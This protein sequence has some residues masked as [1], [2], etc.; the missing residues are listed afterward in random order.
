MLTRLID[1]HAV[2]IDNYD[3]LKDKI[4]FVLLQGYYVTDGDTIAV[5][6][7]VGDGRFS[8]ASLRVQGVDTPEVHTTNALEK[9][10]GK[11]VQNVV[12][13]W[14]AATPGE[15]LQIAEYPGGKYRG[16]FMGDV[17]LGEGQFLSERLLQH[18]LAL[19][20][21]GGTKTTWSTPALQGVIDECQKIMS[22]IPASVRDVSWA[23][24][25]INDYLKRMDAAA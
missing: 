1:L 17:Q 7:D 20:Y 10:A 14:M 13:G 12:N 2:A 6:R 16:R 23:V 18:G 3:R 19:P 5:L 8:F 11:A 15:V 9:I 4:V 24:P 22:T 25:A 21:D